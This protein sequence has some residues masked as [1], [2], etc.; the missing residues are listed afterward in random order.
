M[1]VWHI[2]VRETG[3]DDYGLEPG[4][5]KKIKKY[6]ASA[7]FDDH[8]LLF[9]SALDANKQLA[10]ELYYSISKGLSYEDIDRVCYIPIS[11]GDFYGYQ[12]K[13]LYIFRDMLRLHGKWP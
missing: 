11:K 4:E 1:E 8:L 9:N 6:C 12:R 2:R 5:D 13:T 10:S 3:Y 7:G